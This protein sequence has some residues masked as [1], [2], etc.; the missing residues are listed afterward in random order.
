MTVA[1]VLRGAKVAFFN[2]L[3]SDAQQL[4]GHQLTSATIDVLMIIRVFTRIGLCVVL[5][6]FPGLVVDDGRMR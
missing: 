1:S 4:L 6:H 2:G 3:I 5:A